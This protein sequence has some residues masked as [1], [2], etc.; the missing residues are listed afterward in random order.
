M[1]RVST[2]GHFSLLTALSLQ[3]ASHV[4][5]LP[6]LDLSGTLRQPSGTDTMREGQAAQD[7]Y[8]T[9]QCRLT[10][11][12]RIS[13][14]QL[15][16]TF[17]TLSHR[18]HTEIVES[19]LEHQASVSAV[20]FTGRA[21]LHWATAQ[22]WQEIVDQLLQKRALL[23]TQDRRGWSPML[24]ASQAGHYFVLKT[25]L[26]AEA[27]LETKG[28]DGETAL[29]LAALNGHV[30]VL[31]LLVAR[32][33]NLQARAN[34]G[35]TPL[36][37]A[38]E[39]GNVK[40]VELLVALGAEVPLEGLAIAE[41]AIALPGQDA[42]CR[43]AGD[44]LSLTTRLAEQLA[45]ELISTDDCRDTARRWGFDPNAGLRVLKAVA[46]AGVD[47]TK[48][49]DRL[50]ELGLVQDPKHDGIFDWDVMAPAEP[51]TPKDTQG[52]ET[53]NPKAS[54]NSWT[55]VWISDQAFKPT[56]VSLKAQLEGLGCQVKGYKTHKNAARALDKKR[57]LVRTVVMVTGAEAPPFLQYIATRPELASTPVVVEATSRSIPVRESPT[58]QVC[59]SFD[60]AAN[61]VWKVAHEPG[62]A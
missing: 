4:V 39:A 31:R 33:A 18:G 52:V 37:L 12:S 32:R 15:S 29:M 59:D 28:L 6:A 42:K 57:A 25:L 35:L 58:V 38:A 54:E 14:L 62:F 26:E 19:L 9:V 22:G 11:S 2:Q 20:D 55:L 17:G 8:S 56:A 7:L 3:Q 13:Q 44:G 51:K 60:A 1:V 47:T 30:E 5:A 34:D 61:A 16:A 23:D 45:E 48:L 24:L 10:N 21:A 36:K 53:S 46:A 50:V 40:A 27:A 49:K 43:S 41:A